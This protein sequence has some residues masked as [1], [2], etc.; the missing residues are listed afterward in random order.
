MICNDI[1]A[2]IENKKKLLKQP[3]GGLET[4]QGNDASVIL[5]SL[6]GRS[7]SFSELSHTSSSFSAFLKKASENYG[8]IMR[9]TFS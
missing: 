9:G 1:L 6:K 4:T 2:A 5:T 7:T 8:K 3:V